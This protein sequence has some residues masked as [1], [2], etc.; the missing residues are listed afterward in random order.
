M[1]DH[2]FLPPSGAESWANCAAWPTMNANYP[3]DDSQESREG[4]AAHWVISQHFAGVAVKI[5]DVADNG[6]IVTEEMIDGAGIF[7]AAVTDVAFRASDVFH[8]EG[9]I[10]IPLPDCFGTPDLWFLADGGKHL[11]L[12]DYK[13]GHK[14]VSEI[15]NKQLLCYLAGIVVLHPQIETFSFVIVQ[16]RCYYKGEPVREFTNTVANSAPKFDELQNAAFAA[17]ADGDKFATTG[18]HCAHCPGRFCC[19]A[20]ANQAA[21]AHETSQLSLPLTASLEYA[22]RELREL[23]RAARRMESRITGLREMLASNLRAGKRVPFYHLEQ[24]YGR[25]VWNVGPEIVDGVGIMYGV[26]LKKPAVITP[27]QAKK[28]GIDDAVIAM[29]SYKPIGELKLVA[30][31]LNA[32][33]KQF[34][35]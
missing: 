21:L 24:Q 6:V 1:S 25:Q 20:L 15:W 27:L 32:V 22:A 30:D 11:F 16:P 10:S 2:A 28:K 5:G 19:E 8:C 33:S 35:K 14:F 4:T 12:F 26:D 23:E 34:E 7:Q 18:D 9:R 29:Y 13:F 3:G 31:D 17:I